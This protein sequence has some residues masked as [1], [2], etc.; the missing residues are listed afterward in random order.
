MRH[1]VDHRKL[2]RHTSH[3]RALLRNMV[4]SLI[5]SERIETTLPKAKELRRLAD[6]LVTIAKQGTLH[7]RRQVAAV[8][9]DPEAVKKLFSVLTERFKDRAGGYTRIY[10]FGHRRG[11]DAS[12]AA[13]EYLGYALPQKTTG[14]KQDKKEEKKAPKKA[15]KKAEKKTEKPKKEK[16]PKAEKAEKKGKLAGLFSRKKKEE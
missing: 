11:D 6:R 5:V 4:T 13:I 15:E 9:R 3:R 16:A 10:H 8:V 1:R 12:M 7:A 2:G 14:E